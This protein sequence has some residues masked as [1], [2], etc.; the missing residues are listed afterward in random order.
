MS[1][2]SEQYIDVVLKET[3]KPLSKLGLNDAKQLRHYWQSKDS[4]C[5][6]GCKERIY[7]KGRAMCVSELREL[8]N[9]LNYSVSKNPVVG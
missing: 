1:S 5:S 7:V 6:C 8:L 9:K 3:G 2:A 4:I